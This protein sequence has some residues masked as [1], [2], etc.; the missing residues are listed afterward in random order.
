MVVQVVPIHTQG[1]LQLDRAHFFRLAQLDVGVSARGMGK[2]RRDGVASYS[3]H[4]LTRFREMF[5]WFEDTAQGGRQ[6]TLRLV[7]YRSL[8]VLSASS[9]SSYMDTNVDFNSDLT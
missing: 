8:N 4:P 2:S 1:L 6:A 9:V 5:L 7:R 3:C